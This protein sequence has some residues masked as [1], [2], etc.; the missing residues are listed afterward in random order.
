[1]VQKATIYCLDAGK[2]VIATREVEFTS[3]AQ[4]A[5]LLQSDLHKC[6]RVEAWHEDVCVLRMTADGAIGW[7]SKPKL[8]E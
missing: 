7:S 5:L 3:R 1:M 4:L 2:R 6:A 8:T